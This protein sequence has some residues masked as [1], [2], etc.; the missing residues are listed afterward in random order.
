MQNL[1]FICFCYNGLGGLKAATSEEWSNL[2]S[3]A[4][5]CEVYELQYH[6]DLR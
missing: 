4:E 3:L 1:A 6:C 2:K 5:Y